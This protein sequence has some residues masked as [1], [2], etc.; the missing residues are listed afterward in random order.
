[1]SRFTLDR[2]V[3]VLAVMAAMVGWLISDASAHP[4]PGRDKLKFEQLPMLNTPIPDIDGTVHTYGGHDELSTAYGFP[5][6]PT[7]QIPIYQGKFMADD[8]ADVFND[9]VVHVRW[10]G[11]YFNDFINPQ[12]PVNKFLI[13]FETDIP[14]GPAPSFSRP[15]Q[16]LLNQVVTKAAALSPGSGTYTEALV[17]GPDPIL[18][19]SVYEYNAEL[20]V[21]FPEKADTIYWLKIVALVDVPAGIQFDPYQPEQSPI[22]VTQWGWHNR[23]YTVQNLLAS[24]NVAPGEF[25]EGFV[26]AGVPV[27]HFQ[28]DSVQGDVRIVPSATG[29]FQFPD[30]FQPQENML[31]QLYRDFTDGPGMAIPGTVSI[32]QLSKDLAFAI[33]SVNI[34]EPNTC[35]MF[36]IGALGLAAGRRRKCC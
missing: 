20:T 32:G 25:I 3:Q 27:W 23:D 12:M 30:I 18:N 36:L 2:S 34:P 10:W 26:G 9:P 6:P 4:L 8:F 7:G 28:D 22:G 19:E 35:L 16:P 5:L 33:Y 29:G 24:P 15:G 13:S 31:P 21:P 1:M 14:A 17:R 11:S